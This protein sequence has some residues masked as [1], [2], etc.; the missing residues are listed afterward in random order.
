MT[1]IRNS[2]F[3][4]FFTEEKNYGRDFSQMDLR[5]EI[6]YSSIQFQIEASSNPLLDEEKEEEEEAKGDGSV[7]HS[8]YQDMHIHSD[9]SSRRSRSCRYL[10]SRVS[11]PSLP[12]PLVSREKRIH[13]LGLRACC[14]C[15]CCRI[16]L[17][18]RKGG[19]LMQQPTGP[20]YGR[21]GRQ[22][23]S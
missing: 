1:S 3:S 19:M 14:C 16:L 8:S 5:S 22:A 9:I 23:W 7:G 13:R 11:P 20:E 21:R 2:S 10:H 12:H 15:C 18:I 17:R 4:F 6:I